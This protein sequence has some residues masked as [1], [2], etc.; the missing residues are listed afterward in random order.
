M[1]KIKK[2]KKKNYT[3][4]KKRYPKRGG[5]SV[6]KPNQVVEAEIVQPNQVVLTEIV[7]P[8]QVVEA[9]IVQPNQAV[10]TEIVQP[11]QVVEAEIV[12]PN[13]VVEAEIV[14]QNEKA[15]E[16]RQPNNSP[17][18]KNGN[19]DDDSD[20]G[21][22]I[23]HLDVNETCPTNYKLFKKKKKSFC[24]KLSSKSNLIQNYNNQTP[25][26][27]DITA[28]EKK[29][30]DSNIES[31]KQDQNSL[32][33]FKKTEE[34]LTQKEERGEILTKE[35]QINLQEGK[36]KRKKIENTM[37]GKMKNI[38][39][40]EGP[41]ALRRMTA[42]GLAIAV[43]L[44]LF[45]ALGIVAPGVGSSSFKVFDR[46][47][48]FVGNAAYKKMIRNR[49]KRITAKKKKILAAKKKK[50]LDSKFESGN[51]APAFQNM[52]TQG[53]QMMQN[54][55]Q[56]GNQMIAQGTQQMA[57]MV[58]R[59]QQMMERGNSSFGDTELMP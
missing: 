45:P 53:Q 39:K 6:V 51:N 32:L 9:E 20:R 15:M 8:N 57:P 50:I 24:Y 43:T 31:L 11:N 7:Q 37:R 21:L 56:M 30:L 28:K 27:I 10:L 38:I 5:S 59:G 36:A 29:I 19:S 12:Q 23:F 46:G 3:L 44:L 52:T 18:N 4:K 54:G 33:L 25:L 16:S 42:G 35:E 34:E 48:K 1:S 58:K 47:L 14:S 26:E 40:Q 13:Q 2:R 17:E 22:L 49:K 41:G 55:Q